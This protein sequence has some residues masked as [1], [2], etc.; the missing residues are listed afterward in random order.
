MHNADKSIHSANTINEVMNLNGNNWQAEK[1]STSLSGNIKRIRAISGGSSDILVNRFV[2][3]G[4][5]CALICCD[6]MVSTSVITELIFEPIT[7]IEQQKNASA[8]FHYIQE[9]LLLSTDRPEAE[10]MGSVF[11]LIDSGFAILIAEGETSGEHMRAS[12]KLSVP[13]C[14]RY[15]AG[16][17]A[18]SSLWR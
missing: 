7:G 15:A 17:R 3:G 12:P 18:R 8:L 1:L 11:R 5:S 6:G 14:R 10:D 2:T 9:Q 4:I 13:V 16:S